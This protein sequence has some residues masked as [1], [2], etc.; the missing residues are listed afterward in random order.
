MGVAHARSSR[1]VS[2]TTGVS[3][4]GAHETGMITSGTII[5]VVYAP[6]PIQP[7]PITPVY[8]RPLSTSMYCYRYQTTSTTDTNVNYTGRYAT[9]IPVAILAITPID[10]YT[11]GS[12]ATTIPVEYLPVDSNRSNCYRYR[13]YRFPDR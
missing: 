10:F 6:V 12:N 1:R 3:T 5:P 2:M 7:V 13:Y 11:T 9:L 8:I 4:T